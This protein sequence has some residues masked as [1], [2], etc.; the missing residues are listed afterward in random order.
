[1][2]T[3]AILMLSMA[4]NIIFMKNIDRIGKC[5]NIK[6]ARAFLCE[7]MECTQEELKT[8]YDDND[9][10]RMIDDDNISDSQ[11]QIVVSSRNNGISQESIDLTDLVIENIK[12]TVNVYKD[13]LR[14]YH[15]LTGDIYHVGRKVMSDGKRYVVSYH[16]K[17]SDKVYLTDNSKFISVDV[18]ETK[19]INENILFEEIG[20]LFEET[21]KNID[22]KINLASYLEIFS[23][24][25]DMDIKT[26]ISRLNDDMKRSLNSH[27]KS[28][29]MKNTHGVI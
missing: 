11:Q 19:L 14:F 1:M 4:N 25:Y 13:N 17:I 2:K 8:Y 24:I 15:M 20:E 23:H 6:E 27:L 22:G 10:M 3:T 7:D 26:F 28:Y 18:S 21:W 16:D 12:F 29:L 5:K 9:I